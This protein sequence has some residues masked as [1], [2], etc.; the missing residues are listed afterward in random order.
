MARDV[1]GVLFFAS[2]FRSLGQS[3]LPDYR[4]GNVSV[5]SLAAQGLARSEMGCGSNVPLCGTLTLE[6]G[7][8]QGVYHSKE[9]RVHGLWPETG[10]YGT[11]KCITPQDQSAT[12]KIYSCYA[13]KDDSEEQIL[14]FENHEWTTHGRCAGV[15]DVD[16]FFGQV[17]GLSKDPLGALESAKKA[18]KDL[19]S[20]A[21]VLK[22][23]GYPVWSLDERED[24]ILLSACAGYDGRWILA[25][26]N[27]MP[28]KCGGSSPSP[29][30]SPQPS[31]GG[32]CFPGKKGPVCSSD[33]DCS[34]LDGCVRCAHSGYCTDQALA[35]LV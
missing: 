17:C 4:Y 16:D 10:S 29:S 32:S 7:L 23:Q 8:G 31:P 21:D 27:E 33:A 11:S 20:M 13:D 18:G 22:E 3:P 26:V 1:F 9:A 5:L 28:S 12:S 30:P 25:N 14:W 19:E 15:K 6:S 2:P 24:Q 35:V 34:T